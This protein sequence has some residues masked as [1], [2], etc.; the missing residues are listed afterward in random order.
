MHKKRNMP[1]SFDINFDDIDYKNVSLIRRITSNYAK[2]LPAK[3]VGLS[4]KQQ[5]KLARAVK[6][7]RT[8]ALVAYTR[9]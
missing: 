8:M 2:I 6:R 5:R 4:S 3:R 1:M 9:Q 7:S